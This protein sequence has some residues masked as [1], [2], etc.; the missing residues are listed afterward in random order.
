M[1]PTDDAINQV[2]LG[3]A[4]A[5]GMTEAH[6]W[7]RLHPRGGAEVTGPLFGILYEGSQQLLR[8]RKAV[9]FD[10]D[11]LCSGSAEAV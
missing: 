9:H 1:V 11:D 7:D 3:N 2:T 8:R 4:A 6:A 10:L 5:A